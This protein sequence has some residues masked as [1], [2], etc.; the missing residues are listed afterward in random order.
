MIGKP[1]GRPRKPVPAENETKSHTSG[2]Q[3][4]AVSA[5]L[6]PAPH[7]ENV[8]SKVSHRLKTSEVNTIQKGMEE[9]TIIEPRI[10]NSPAVHFSDEVMS[11]SAAKVDSS[12]SDLQ[13]V[14]LVSSPHIVN[15]AAFCNVVNFVFRANYKD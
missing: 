5:G 6:A 13:R 2:L 1:R 8:F 12:M 11:S 7:V 9:L 4:A 10:V 3:A 14:D 15:F